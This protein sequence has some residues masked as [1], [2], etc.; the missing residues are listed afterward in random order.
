MIEQAWQNIS[1]TRPIGQ[2][3]LV[4]LTDWIFTGIG[5]PWKM[6]HDGRSPTGKHW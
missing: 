1:G 2:E 6:Q 4:M 3:T 5:A